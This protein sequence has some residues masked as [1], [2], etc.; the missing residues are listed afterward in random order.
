VD[1]VDY[2]CRLYWRG[3]VS[4]QQAARGYNALEKWGLARWI[5]G[6]LDLVFQ[7]QLDSVRYARGL[8]VMS[9]GMKETLLRTYP[10]LSP[11]KIF[12]S[13]WGV[14]DSDITPRSSTPEISRMIVTL[15]RIT[16]EKG[17]DRLLEA[18]RLWESQADY[19]HEGVTYLCLGEAAYMQGR[20]FEA[21]LRKLAKRL[22]RTRVVFT[23][24]VHGRQK[25]ELL[26]RAELYVF[27]SRHESY[28][29]TLL[30]AMQAGLPVLSTPTYGARDIITPERGFL[31]QDAEGEQ[32]PEQLKKGLSALLTDRER[33]KTQG[34]AARVFARTQRFDDSA[35]RLADWLIHQTN[36]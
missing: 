5:P 17:Q 2:F 9:Q 14:P 21:R 8:V 35:A 18:L 11:E 13:P 6:Y 30:E 28:G 4:P 25:A 10:T 34:E 32:V 7:K 12:L 15:S 19:P 3:W 27:P 20:R 22:K 23:G 16:P 26:A 24:Y 36:R 31:T 29:L 1:V 33:L